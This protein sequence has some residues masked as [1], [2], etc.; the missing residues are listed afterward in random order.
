MLPDTEGW[1]RRRS[2]TARD[3]DA[4]GVAAAKAGRRLSVV[5]PA[6]DEE[7]TVGAIVTALREHLVEAVPLL[8]EIVVIDSD[9]TDNTARVARAAGAEVHAQS[10]ILPEWG[11]VP[12]KGE[13]LWKSLAVTTGD[14]VAFIDAD[15][16]DFDPTFAVGLLAPLVLDPSLG[17]VKGCYDRPLADGATVLPSGGGRVTELVARPLIDAWWPELAGFVQPLAGEYAATREVLEQ[18]PFARGYGVELALLVDVWELVGLDAMAQVDLGTRR[19]R[20]S[21]DDSLARMA[22][23]IQLTA[24]DRLVRAGRVT[25]TAEPHQRLTTFTRS[26][27]GAYSPTTTRIETGDRP[28]MCEV[29][30]QPRAGS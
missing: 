18:I 24:L 11:S 20:N 30:V 5:L 12:G 10:E 29:R 2:L 19:H 14:V 28:P 7:A 16:R 17:F 23:Q 8:D 15:L 25:T 22:A 27:A 3:F 26:L 6:R 13:A 21:P 4:A 9:S 1:F